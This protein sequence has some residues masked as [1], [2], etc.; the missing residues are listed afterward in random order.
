M[1]LLQRIVAHC[2]RRGLVHS[3]EFTLLWR[4]GGI[5]KDPS[6]VVETGRTSVEAKLFGHLV[7]AFKLFEAAQVAT[8]I[9]LFALLQARKEFRTYFVENVHFLLRLNGLWSSVAGA[10][11]AKVTAEAALTTGDSVVEH[12]ESFLVIGRGRDKVLDQLHRIGILVIFILAFVP[13]VIIA[14]SLLDGLI[15]F[16]RWERR[17][18]VIIMVFI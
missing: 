17:V 4:T 8:Q 15:T 13:F 7:V 5:A 18:R 9:G 16:D 12:A 2:D 6:K 10:W 1:H 3:K 11:N 14:A